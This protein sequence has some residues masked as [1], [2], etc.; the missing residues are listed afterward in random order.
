MERRLNQI[1]IGSYKLRAKVAI[2]KGQRGADNRKKAMQKGHIKEQSFVQ[3]GWLYVQA[4]KGRSVRSV[5]AQVWRKTEGT[6]ERA[7][8]VDKVS[9]TQGNPLELEV[10][11]IGENGGMV[12]EDSKGIIDFSPSKEENKWLEGSFVAVV[13]SM[14]LVST[15][16]ERVDV[17]GGLINLSPL[18]GRSLLLT[19][20]SQ[21]FLSEY[22]QQNKDLLDLWCEAIYP[23]AKAPLN[24]GRMAWLRI[25]GVPLKAWCDRCFERI[26]EMVGEVVMVHA[27]TKSKSILCDGHVLILCTAKQK[28]S[29]TLKLKMEEKVFEIMVTEEEWRVD[30]DW[31]LA[32]EDRQGESSTGSEYSLSENGEKD[33]E[34]LLS[35]IRSEDLVDIAADLV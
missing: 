4:I 12:G 3:P 27:D 1:W 15:I 10:A 7:V 19:E 14:S 29:R 21:G 6:Q 18:G 16:Q 25:S 13:R 23:W 35:E 22:I 34:L 28:I 32:E 5:G 20:C 17:D 9:T 26:A 31:W 11:K 24:S 2:A 33:P 30:P 8:P